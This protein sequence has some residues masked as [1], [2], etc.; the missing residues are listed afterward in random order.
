MLR[1][2]QFSCLQYNLGE[3]RT[4][5]P[6]NTYHQTDTEDAPPWALTHPQEAGGIV[7]SS[8]MQTRRPGDIT[9]C[10]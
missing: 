4:E 2:Q 3:M 5:T 10:I 8:Q 6:K 1:T 7:L 9:K